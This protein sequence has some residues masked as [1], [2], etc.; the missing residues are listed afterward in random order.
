MSKDLKRGEKGSNMLVLAHKH[1]KWLTVVLTCV[2]ILLAETKSFLGNSK[3]RRI[4][5]NRENTAG[6]NTPGNKT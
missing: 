2:R 1:E 4:G 6:Q 5:G 3:R